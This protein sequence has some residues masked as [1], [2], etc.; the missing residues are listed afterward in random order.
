MLPPGEKAVEAPRPQMEA[1]RKRLPGHLL[2]DCYIM[3]RAG[4]SF[5]VLKS[6]TEKMNK[7]KTFGV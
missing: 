4:F 1:T 3:F 5:C 6:N 2:N 7:C